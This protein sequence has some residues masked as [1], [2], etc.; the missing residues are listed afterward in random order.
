MRRLFFFCIITLVGFGLYAYGNPRI[1]LKLEG[2]FINMQA[3]LEARE[4]AVSLT[5]L[6]RDEGWTDFPLPASAMRAKIITNSILARTSL[7]AGS[8]TMYPYSVDYQV[9]DGDS[10][11]VLKEGT[12]YFRTRLSL[13][14]FPPAKQP[15]QAASLRESELVPADGRIIQLDLENLVQPV[16]NVK[17][18]LKNG[19]M[20]IG[21]RGI[22]ARVYSLQQVT[23]QRESY[24]WSRLHGKQKEQLAKGNTY[25]QDFLTESE[26]S[27]LMH[28]QWHAAGPAGVPNRDFTVRRLYIREDISDQSV[29]D[30]SESTD[31]ADAEARPFSLAVPEEG[32]NL[33]FIFK[34]LHQQQASAKLITLRW[35]GKDFHENASW[36]IPLTG[37]PENFQHRFAGGMIVVDTDTPLQIQ[38]FDVDDQNRQIQPEPLVQK[39][40]PSEPTHWLS[41]AIRHIDTQATPVRIT[42][43][44]AAPLSGNGHHVLQCRMT[45]G[46]DGLYRQELLDFTYEKSR[47]DWL[48][49]GLA[50]GADRALSEPVNYYLNLPREVTGLHFRSTEPLLLAVA[51]RPPDFRHTTMIPEDSFKSSLA[52]AGRP[53]WFT[54]PPLDFVRLEAVK[55]VAVIEMQQ[56]PP[57]RQEDFLTGQFHWESFR[58]EGRWQGSYLFAPRAE[59]VPLRQEAL[60]TTFHAVATTDEMPISVGGPARA[61]TVRP[62]LLF[63]RDSSRPLHLQLEIDGRSY[64]E[65]DIKAARGN[66]TL[67]PL[68]TGNHILRLANQGDGNFFISNLLGGADAHSLRFGYRLDRQ[69]L[70]FTIPKK[71]AEELL[72][73]MYYAPCGRAERTRIQVSLLNLQRMQGPFSGFTQNPRLYDIRSGD[74]PSLPLLQNES[75]CTDS[76]Q[77]FFF[78]LG[79]DLPPGNYRL[80]VETEGKGS[81]LIF[82]Y[83]VT[84]GQY[85]WSRFFREED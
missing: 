12:Y 67:P 77:R 26:I 85:D 20:D 82:V 34:P 47:Y 83:Q 9:L 32:Q 45:T 18:R 79:P 80:K 53:S 73:L 51:N 50:D 42:I 74:G 4:T 7:T 43:R 55:K 39:M 13:F 78:P 22:L 31:S 66:I 70:V 6:L 25:P 65:S 60:A 84:A 16:K 61:A 69:D 48:T 38:V 17:I 30:V 33:H 71:Q 52:A 3:D 24:L 41:Y 64:Y 81:G 37:Q 28:K 44:A 2:L 46:D 62:K 76:G 5:Y 49:E 36:S 63:L 19:K 72:S 59:A 23:G 56:R 1:L 75:D 68:T 11:T 27:H 57:V 10:R 54:F 21:V 29:E 8:D 58:P 15:E 40:Y 14:H 35:F